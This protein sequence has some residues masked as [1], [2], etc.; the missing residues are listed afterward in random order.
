MSS[1]VQVVIPQNEQ[2]LLGSVEKWITLTPHPHDSILMYQPSFT[3]DAIII[4]IYYY[5]S[6]CSC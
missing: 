3:E 1:F 6:N 5:Y 4:I 2:K